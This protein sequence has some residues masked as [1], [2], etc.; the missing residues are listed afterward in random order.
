MRQEKARR[1]SKH[2]SESTISHRPEEI[3]VRRAR[4]PLAALIALLLALS[5][6]AVQPDSD[7]AALDRRGVTQLQQVATGEPMIG[8]ATFP[9]RVP[10][11]ADV[12]NLRGLGL[13]VQPMQHLPLALLRG[14]PGAM[15]LAV[16]RGFAFDVYPDEQL[17]YL[18]AESAAAINAPAVWEELGYDGS[19][20]GVAI[21]DTGIDA[22]HPDLENRVT[23]NVKILGSEYVTEY[24]DHASIAVPVDQGPYNN[25]DNT[26]GHGT[27]VAGIVAA[28]GTDGAHDPPLLGVAP[29]A[30]LI[31]YSTGDALFIFEIIATFDHVIE[32]KDEWNIDITNNSWGSSYRPYDPLHPINLATKAVTDA[33]ILN[34]FAAGNSTDEM[35]INPWSVAPWI[36]S[37]GSATTSKERSSFSSGGLM[38]D[39]S[40]AQPLPSGEGH[41]RYEGDRIGLYHPDV[42]A[43][44]SDIRSTGTPTAVGTLSPTTPGGTATLSGT[45]MATPHVAGLA[46]L[47][48]DAA[49]HLTP[50]Q[51]RKVMEVTAVPMRDASPFWHSGYGFVDAPSAIELVTSRRMQA[52]PEQILNNLRRKVDKEV[53]AARTHSVLSTDQWWFDALPASYGGLDTRSFT[54]PVTEETEAIRATASFPPDLGVVGINFFFNWG[55]TLKDVD[56][57]VVGESEVSGSSGFS[58]LQ[59]D[60][61][62]VEDGVAFGDWTLE[63]SGLTSVNDPAWYGRQVEVHLA[64]LEEQ[65]QTDSGPTFTA[66]GTL[67]LAFAGDDD[68]SGLTTPE[69]CEQE[70]GVADGTLVP[71][72]TPEA[73]C[74][75]GLSGY[76]TNY[77]A[78]IPVQF[79]S[80]PLAEQTTV[81]GDAT[82]VFY[83]TEPAQPVWSSVFATG[84]AYQLDAV[85]PDTGDVIAVAGGETADPGKV[86]PTPTRNEHVVPIPPTEVPAGYQLRLQMRFSGFYTSDMRF[87]YGGGDWADAG[88]TLQTGTLSN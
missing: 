35:Q 41:V 45:S 66:E 47:I 53:L 15:I 5:V 12:A 85:D 57:K 43:P 38:F 28:D 13:E 81:G 23:H 32:M 36:V 87:V 68:P 31:G 75:S 9:G 29:G 72:L 26:S 63:V 82:L 59:V 84:P 7:P 79:T 19:G 56:G 88:I 71:S 73:V 30:D 67:P 18:D 21:I 46:A 25:T 22:T 44:G 37:V 86:G 34:V 1:P 77:A 33:G 78:S 52:A 62:E 83:L 20:V 50:D 42:S 10:T 60:L 4:V 2:T 3:A 6:A 8:I 64:Q 27:H 14:T 58:W 24:E 54:V 48:L 80:A 17:E 16:E 11:D 55:L 61:S 39:N 51:V 74:Q 69:G 70:D 76:A 65:R 49:P 40:L